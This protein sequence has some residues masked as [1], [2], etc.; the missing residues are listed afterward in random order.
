VPSTHKLNILFV[1]NPVSGGQPKSHW[2]SFIVSQLKTDIHDFEIYHTTGKNDKESIR[3]YIKTIKPDRVVAAGG[4]GTLKM[5]AEIL[6]G[7]GIPLGIIPAGSANGMARELGI[8]FTPEECLDVILN[9]EI[10]KIDAV[11]IN[12]HDL[13]LHLS[14]IGM[15]AQLV[16]YFEERGIRGKLG[17]VRGI[18]K[19]LLRRRLLQVT[20]S[21]GK[22]V[23]QREAFMV[24]IANASMYGTGA[25][26]NPD[27]DLSDGLFEIV[28]VKRMSPGT[29]L[30]M[31]L[32]RRSFNKEKLEIL[33]VQSVDI[34]VQHRAYFQVDGEYKGKMKRIKARIEKQVLSV[35]VP[36]A[37]QP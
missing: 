14:D 24:V 16:K 10:R 5:V 23:W 29:V 20:I 34:E 15:N 9:G 25:M 3:H 1:F 11:R 8:P 7:T 12:T 26:I 17:Y 32:Q 36:P 22:N 27:G 33:Q 18:F 37:T 19:M 13:C 31:F 35:I 30:K 28:I 21:D 6:A 4:D 2:E